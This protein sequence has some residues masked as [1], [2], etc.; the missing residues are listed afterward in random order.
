MRIFQ[1]IMNNS[2]IKH[3]I[4]FPIFDVYYFNWYPYIRTS[5]HDHAENG[6]LMILLKGELNEKLYNNKLEI[7][8]EN[9]YIFPNISFINNKKG[10]HSIKALKES[11]SV[12]I[13]YP[14]GHITRSYKK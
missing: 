2:N 7:I 4:P 1:R 9:N 5:I 10:Y 6:C 13:Y 11:S 8:N 3:H 14:K 12:H